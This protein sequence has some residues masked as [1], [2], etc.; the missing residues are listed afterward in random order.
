MRRRLV[1]AQRALTRGESPASS[2]ERA[3][4]VAVEFTGAR[5]KLSATITQ[6]RKAAALS[7]DSEANSGS[8]TDATPASELQSKNSEL[9]FD[10]SLAEFEELT[11]SAGAEIAATLVR[12]AT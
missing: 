10:A 7:A 11:L 3:L 12:A 2:R 4:L 1:E 6:A 9:D 5:R 8:E